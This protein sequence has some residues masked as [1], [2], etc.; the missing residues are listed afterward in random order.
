MSVFDD[1]AKEF[2]EYKKN[3]PTA[4]VTVVFNNDNVDT[5]NIEIMNLETKEDAL[6]LSGVGS[7]SEGNAAPFK[8]VIPK[9]NILQF[10]IYSR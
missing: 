8:M 7:D 10:I 9:T 5:L 6:L 3:Y 2:A 4:P 1:I